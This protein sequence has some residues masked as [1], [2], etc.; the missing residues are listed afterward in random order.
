MTD[1]LLE[2]LSEEIPAKMQLDIAEKFKKIAS[3]QLTKAGIEAK[4]E[5][6]N[7]LI[8]PR[9][10]T[11]LINNLENEQITPEIKRFGPKIDA[12]D[13]AI[14]GFVK[15]CGLNDTNQLEI[16][17]N[18]GHKCFFFQ[19]KCKN[20]ATNKILSATLPIILQKTTAAWPK[21][22]RYTDPSGQESKWI[23][24][25]RNIL[26]IFGEKTIEIDFFGLKSNNQTFGHFLQ[27][28]QPITIERPTKYQDILR[29]NHVIIDQNERKHLILDQVNKI[30]HSLGFE[31]VDNENSPIFDELT[32]LCEFP[33]ALIGKIDPEFMDLPQEILILTLKLHQ[34]SLCLQEKDG[35]LAPNFIFISNSPL[36]KENCAKITKDNEN[37]SRARL[38]DAEFF[39]NEDLKNPLID[40]YQK[41]KNI[42]FHQKLDSVFERCERIEHLGE[43]L[44]LWINHCDISQIERASNLCKSDLVSQTVAEFPELQ[45][46]IASFLAKKQGETAEVTSAIYEHYLPLGPTSEL[47][48][49]P[50]GIALA[51]ADKTDLISGMFLAGDKPTSSKDPF[52]LRRAALGIIRICLH[53]NLAI[54]F[55]V[56]INKSLKIYKPKLVKNLLDEK[57]RH[58]LG[59]EITKFF[60]ERLKNLLKDDYSIRSD[61]TNAVIDDYIENFNDHKYGDIVNLVNKAT[62]VNEIVKNPENE[63][64]VSL[65]KRSNNILSA[66]EKKDG[67]IFK[68]RIHRLLLKIDQEKA[69]YKIIKEISSN[70]KKMVKKGEFGEAFRLLKILEIP[71]A[72]FFE[73][74]IVNDENSKIRHNR[75][76]MLSKIREMFLSVADFSKIVLT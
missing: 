33:T 18:K 63:A 44:A 72:H 7:T 31:T 34:K 48:Q 76:V 71:L 49:S 57:K 75:L 35:N 20:I 68:G 61:V 21:L 51:I 54:P 23:R 19:E 13:K 14:Q 69:L 10:L 66:E 22:M 30:K 27:S 46:K 12:N 59:E 55:R 47:P 45:G 2:I 1:F 9:R 43:F 53:H 60:F 40:N 17:E 41:L 64:L 67:A 42:T 16:V 8:S 37:V 4:I 74:V 25:V 62:T 5:Q 3:E 28:N 38:K 56:L 26:S 58:E 15:S 36:A 32:G 6:F 70:F 73:K 29:Q 11:L 52:A 50:I 39:I 24:P 65:Y